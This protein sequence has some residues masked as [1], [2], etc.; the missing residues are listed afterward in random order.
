MKKLLFLFFFYVIATSAQN[1]LID[2][3]EANIGYINVQGDFGER[4]VFSSTLPNSG[5]VFGAKVYFN[6]LDPYRGAGRYFKFPLGLNVG[7]T[8]LSYSK[9][10]EDYPPSASLE[11]LKAINGQ[12]FF[13]NLNV[14]AEYHLTD[15]RSFNVFTSNFFSKFDP[16]VGLGAGVSFYNVDIESDLGNYERDPS[17]LPVPLQGRVFSGP[18]I[19]P[20]VN[21]EIGLRYQFSTDLLLN[22]SNK[23]NYYLL[24]DRVDGIQP[25]ENMVDN[26]SNDW[27]FYPTLGV[28]IFIY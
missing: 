11:K 14:G 7:F 20:F 26:R 22:I 23:W 24:S 21:L 2:E 25:K 12:L 5:A 3:W 6:L 19:E 1:T 9:A 4:S 28:V 18:G 8:N 16:Y 27:F 13:A 15:L 17:I 10:Y